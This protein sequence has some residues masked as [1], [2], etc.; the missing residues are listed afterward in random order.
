MKRSTS[1]LPLRS[2]TEKTRGADGV[3]LGCT[4]FGMLAPPGI[5]DLPAVDTAHAH[6]EAAIAFALGGG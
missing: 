4:E 1:S 5:F 6:A 2:Q 3:I